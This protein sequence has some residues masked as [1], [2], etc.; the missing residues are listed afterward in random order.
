MT[1]FLMECNDEELETWQKVTEVIEID[2]DDDPIFV[3]EVVCLDRPDNTGHTPALKHSRQMTSSPAASSISIAGEPQSS[4]LSI[5]KSTAPVTSDSRSVVT[6]E[7][8]ASSE[9]PVSNNQVV[10]VC[11]S[12]LMQQPTSM[13]HSQGN[14]V[15]LGGVQNP[16]LSNKSAVH[17]LISATPQPPAKSSPATRQPPA[18]SSQAALQPAKQVNLMSPLG[19]QHANGTSITVLPAFNPLLQQAKT[20]QLGQGKNVVSLGI[21]QNPLLA[22]KSAFQLINVIPEPAVLASSITLLPAAQL[23]QAT[24]EPAAQSSPSPPLPVVQSV[25][26]TVRQVLKLVR[27]QVTQQAAPGVLCKPTVQL[28]PNNLLQTV[29][30]SSVVQQSVAQPSP[31]NLRK[32]TN[33]GSVVGKPI[34]QPGCLPLKGVVRSKRKKV[35]AAPGALCKQPPPTVQAKKDTLSSGGVLKNHM[36]VCC[37]DALNKA[38]PES[39][40]Q[41]ITDICSRF[42]NNGK[43]VMLVSEFYYGNHCGDQT[44][45]EKLMTDKIYRCNNCSKLITNNIGLMDHMKHHFV[46]L[47]HNSKALAYHNTCQHCYRRYKTPLLLWLH[48]EGV[49]TQYHSTT[50]C[51]IC[52]LDFEKEQSLLEHMR[53]THKPGE[54]PYVCQV[55]NFRSSFFSEVDSHF[56]SRHKN[57]KNLLCPFCL[58]VL[59]SAQMY[60]SHFIKHQ[61]II[62]TSLRAKSGSH[63]TES[64]PS[65]N[66]MEMPLVLQSKGKEPID[67]SPLEGDCKALWNIR[68]HGAMPSEELRKK[69]KKSCG[70]LW[71]IKLEC[72]NCDFLADLSDT[73]LMSKHLIER[74]HHTCRVI[75]D[76]ETC[77]RIQKTLQ[78]GLSAGNA[79]LSAKSGAFEEQS[80]AQHEG[81]VLSL[82][83]SVTIRKLQLS[84]VSLMMLCGS[85]RLKEI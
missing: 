25:P 19:T 63:E 85:Q 13:Q 78:E 49:H 37:I 79:H 32:P 10:F 66:S 60:V 26:G 83:F 27:E 24:A 62:C 5:T 59:E 3:K 36:K 76:K 51:K 42:G 52:E 44:A 14:V 61:V 48:T 35:Q 6:T 68:R 40:T 75:I 58:K 8:N 17:Q 9:P 69:H 38:F 43:L 7:K 34:A 22:R 50:N 1:E 65:L 74:S 31:L 54:M 20:V 53:D 33:A 23:S 82:C 30:P 56:R 47:C 67:P 64:N 77:E 80:W 46:L 72:L 45:P 55:C 2:D 57:T 39:P 81:I 84:V 41:C 18:Q 11:S 28:S 16:L 73:N 70:I 71:D 4:L 12:P 21:V 29:L 15:I